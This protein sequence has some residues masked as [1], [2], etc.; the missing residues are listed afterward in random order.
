MDAYFSADPK[1]AGNFY[2]M[3]VETYGARAPLIYKSA[4]LNMGF[5]DTSRRK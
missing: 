5:S 1:L 3:I 2:K 4:N